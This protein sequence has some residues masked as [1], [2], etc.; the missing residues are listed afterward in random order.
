MRVWIRD[1]ALFLVLAALFV[2]SWVGQLVS[3]WFEFVN[4][5][6]E[7]GQTTVF[8]SSQFWWAFGQST[9]ENWQ[10]EW[11]QLSAQILLPAYLIYKGA[12][13]S[14]DSSERMEALVTAIARKTGVDPDEVYAELPEKYRP[15]ASEREEMERVMKKAA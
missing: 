10:S 13:T 8:W 2:T 11:L 3:Q 14:R 5:Q 12:T 15:S 4:E 9:F 6:A 1:R 7:H